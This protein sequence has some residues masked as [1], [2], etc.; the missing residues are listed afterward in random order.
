MKPITTTMNKIAV[1]TNILVYLYDVTDERKRNISERLVAEKPVI[2]PQVISE[3]INVTKRLLKLPKIEILKRCNLVF[4]KCIISPL[5]SKTLSYALFLLEKYDF[6]LFDAIIVASALESNC[7][8]LYSEDLQHNQ[9]IE[10]RLR[11]IN[12]FL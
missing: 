10:S 3:Y 1:D 2:S 6:Q 4:E 11:I 8:I 5:Q 7:S 9:L 12:P